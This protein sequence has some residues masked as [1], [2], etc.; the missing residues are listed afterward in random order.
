MV[1]VTIC[2]GTRIYREGLSLALRT[3]ECIDAVSSCESAA[4]LLSWHAERWPDVVLLDIQSCPGPLATIADL[5]ASRPD[6]DRCSIVV[7]GLGAEEYQAVVEFLSAGAAGYATVNDS[8]EKLA[9]VLLA[10]AR[11][12]W[13]SAPR[14]ARLMQDRLLQAPVGP[15]ATL[16]TSLRDLSRREREV[17]AL[18]GQGRSNK[19]IARQLSLEP[20]TVK[21]HMHSAIT[22]L[23][24]RNRHEAARAFSGY[25]WEASAQ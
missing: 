3:Y 18:A 20:T 6:P 25:H 19:E 16:A 14:L 13:P 10:A 11:G 15:Q 9:D 17:L 23:R 1:S 5:R 12:E 24:V 4:R 22:K 7:L 2:G 21:N 8:I